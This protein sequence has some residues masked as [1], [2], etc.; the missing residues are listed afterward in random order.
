[1]KRRI[2]L[3]TTL[4]LGLLDPAKGADPLYDVVV[5]GDSSGAV[6]AAI[7]A[8][9]HGR[10]VIL[11]NPTG[12]PGGM[13]ASGLGATDFLG[14]QGSLVAKAYGKDFVRPEAYK[15]SAKPAQSPQRKKP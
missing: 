7:D 4:L 1:M 3:F 13:S 12:F 2:T 14:K 8:K 5:Y 10:S 6:V 9:R 11:V 15:P